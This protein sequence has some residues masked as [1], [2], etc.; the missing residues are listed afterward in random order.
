MGDRYRLQLTRLSRSLKEKRPLYVQRQ[1]KVILL[2][3]NARPHAAK[4]VKIYLET[5]QLKSIALPHDSL[6]RTEQL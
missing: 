1:D 5:L 3:D 4:P 2:H 6:I